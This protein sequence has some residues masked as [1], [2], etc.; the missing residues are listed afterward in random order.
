MTG[1]SAASFPSS[2]SSNGLPPENRIDVLLFISFENVGRYRLG[3]RRQNRVGGFHLFPRAIHRY[4]V[5]ARIAPV[6][7]L[8]ERLQRGLNRNL[9]N[10][11]YFNLLGVEVPNHKRPEMLCGPSL[12]KL[13]HRACAVAFRGRPGGGLPAPDRYQEF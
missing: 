6:L 2:A 3:R 8:N 1:L 12:R 4:G 9:G 7:V 13:R 11:E 5:L 10:F